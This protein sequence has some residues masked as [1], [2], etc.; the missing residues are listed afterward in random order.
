M[1][2]PLHREPT[3]EADRMGREAEGHLRIELVRAMNAGLI[4]GVAFPDAVVLSMCG[5]LYGIELKATER[6][7]PPPFEGQGPPV[8][9]VGYYRTLEPF[10]ATLVVVREPSGGE[11][12]QWLHVLDAGARFDTRGTNKTPRRVYP[13]ENYV[14]VRL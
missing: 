13:I 2:Q 1:L 4:R 10:M 6:F 9:Q 7:T 14:A 3:P 5:F 8:A 12:R 11:F